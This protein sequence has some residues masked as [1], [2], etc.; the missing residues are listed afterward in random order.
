MIQNRWD[1]HWY[2]WPGCCGSV[3][4]PGRKETKLTLGRKP[5]S[6]QLPGQQELPPPHSSPGRLHTGSHLPAGRK[7]GSAT[8]VPSHGAH[9]H[10]QR[11]Q[12]C[13]L[14]SWYG[15]LP[16]RHWLKDWGLSQRPANSW[17]AGTTRS[18][19]SGAE[20]EHAYKTQRLP[21]HRSLP[22]VLFSAPGPLLWE[23]LAAEC[24]FYSPPPPPSPLPSA[25]Q[26]REGF[27][28]PRLII[29]NE[30][31]HRK[32]PQASGFRGGAGTKSRVRLPS[33]P[34]TKASKDFLSHEV[35]VVSHPLKQSSV[36]TL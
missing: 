5:L 19:S 26:C 21:P 2:T 22:S 12:Q 34:H 33:W 16:T 32:S 9:S 17:Q 18:L 35:S 36:E 1:T 4:S 11:C 23:G 27:P 8:S 13:Q 24:A 20:L 3:S 6:E 10:Q 28:A 29:A 7:S 25:C 31:V 14:A 15:Y 30:K